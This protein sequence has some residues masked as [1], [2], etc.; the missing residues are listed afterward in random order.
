MDK[1]LVWADALEK[2]QKK[3][4]T[5][6]YDLW[7]KSLEPVDFKDGVFYL[8][9][10]SETAKQRIMAILKNDIISSLQS[11]S[12]EIK[13]F[14]VL[15]P[16]ERESY[17]KDQD[18]AMEN[19]GQKYPGVNTFNPKYTFD[20]FI[21]GNSNKYVYAACKGVAESPH[22]RINPL[23]IYGGVGLGKTHLLH[24]VGNYINK[25]NPALKV[26]YVTC[27]KFTS[28]YVKSL[29]G[30]FSATNSFKEKYRNLDVLIVDD[31]QFIS[32][33]ESTQEE[34]FHTFNELYENNKQI[35]IASDRPPREIATLQERL[36]SRFSMGL[37]QDIQLPDYETRLA[38]LM[39]KAQEENYVVADDVIEY[40]AEHFDT[41]IREMEGILS[42]VWFYASLTCK[43][44]ATM[45][46]VKEALK[47]HDFSDKQ[48]LTADRI[49][50]CVCKYFSVRREDLLGKKKNKEIVEPRQICMYTICNLLDMPLLSI[51]Q[52]FDRD[53]TTVIHARD[54]ITQMM[55]E[56]QRIKIAV[57]D[58][59]AMATKN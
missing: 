42:K 52:L 5:I 15:D 59:R 49:I 58:I 12:D 1:Q 55:E 35:I 28:D 40:I 43:K 54:K 37:I 7:V 39:K 21:V 30:N 13:D 24:A 8:S 2:L 56:N 53:H 29:H 23:F 48:N 17:N 6:S 41:N 36:R 34:F 26:M 47:D 50:D 20:N 22:S 57:S 25:N 33:A 18:L 32:K 45:D 27:E 4:S 31:I 19:E 16:D 3:V 46:D 11:C 51:G 14:Q 44:V 10:T 38:I 9:T